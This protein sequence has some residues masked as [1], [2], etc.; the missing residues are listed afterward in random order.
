MSRSGN[1]SIGEEGAQAAAGRAAL[2]QESLWLDGK[3]NRL[4]VKYTYSD[5]M[6]QDRIDWAEERLKM[7]SSL[8]CLTFQKQEAPKKKDD[9]RRWCHHDKVQ[10]EEKVV[11]FRPKGG[12]NYHYGIS[13]SKGDRCTVY[14]LS[15]ITSRDV[16]GSKVGRMLGLVWV[17]FRPDRDEYIS[18]NWEHLVDI[19]SQRST[20]KHIFRCWDKASNVPIPFDFLS[21]MSW[22][23]YNYNYNDCVPSQVTRDPYQQYL[24]EY[25]N[26]QAPPTS[27]LDV[28][29][30]NMMYKCVPEWESACKASGKEV[31]KCKNFGYV[32]RECV[33]SCLPVYSGKL[34]ETKISTNFPYPLQDGSFNYTINSGGVYDLGKL[35]P[36]R[37]PTDEALAAITFIVVKLEPTGTAVLPFVSVRWGATQDWINLMKDDDMQHVGNWD[38][39]WGVRI[40]WGSKNRDGNRRLACECASMLGFNEFK[41][42][43][44]VLSARSRNMTLT[45]INRFGAWFGKGAEN[46]KKLAIES[47]KYVLETRFRVPPVLTP[48]Q[49]RSEDGDAA[50]GNGTHSTETPLTATA[51]AMTAVGGAGGMATMVGAIAALTLLCLLCLLLMKR[52]KKKKG[53]ELD[54]EE[55]SDDNSSASGSD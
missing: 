47:S 10:R 34:C 42:N 29:T 6:P 31:P 15:K 28:Q 22:H 41:E 11:Y 1:A 51:A 36:I 5:D 7:W 24:L 49:N 54:E 38:C 53:G 43:A 17:P 9:L 13:P 16:N 55:D 50:V 46:K 18:W 44:R 12:H 27:P 21:I 4:T 14:Q 35:L 3:G 33:C 40:L 52:R 32:S 25:K 19:L 23:S 26:Y 37:T 45:F 2:M 8:T 20:M 48:K 39:N 30:L